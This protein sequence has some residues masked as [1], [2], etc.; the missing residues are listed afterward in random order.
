MYIYIY[1]FIDMYVNKYTHLKV[2]YRETSRTTQ[3][4]SA[5][6]T[7]EKLDLLSSGLV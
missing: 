5:R 1:L 2:Q 6:M 3:V 4:V 7:V